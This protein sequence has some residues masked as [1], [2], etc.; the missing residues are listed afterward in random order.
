M[1]QRLLRTA[2]LQVQHRHGVVTQRIARVAL[3]HSRVRG[4]VF[5]ARL[6]ARCRRRAGR[7]QRC[8][9]DELH[10]E[11][12]HLVGR[13]LAPDD[14]VRRAERIARIA[15]RVVEG[16]THADRAALRQ[17]D[18]RGVPVDVLPPEVPVANGDQRTDGPVGQA[19]FGEH[20]ATE[21][22][23]MRL[24]G[25]HLR[26][27]RQHVTVADVVRRLS[28]GNVDRLAAQPQPD[29]HPHRRNVGEEETD[30]HLH[31][32]GLAGRLQMQLHH[33]VA[34]RLEAPRH[35]VGRRARLLTGRPPE[36]VPGRI[37]RVLHHPADVARLW[38]GGVE[39]AG[40]SRAVDA[41]VRV[42]HPAAVA[43]PEL[44]RAGRSERWWLESAA[45][46]CGRDRGRQASACTPRDIDT[47]RSGWPSCQ[48][49][50]YA[51]TGG[52]ARGS[53]SG[54]PCAAQS[55]MV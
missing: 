36:Q 11:V 34:P 55:W 7:G 16:E 49:S 37:G 17:L 42:M 39:A 30:A 28:R 48:P 3:Q 43:R 31:R 46:R 54:P 22:V 20:L 50:V 23:R 47:T 41:E 38:I 8:A 4:D 25:E 2:V 14:A 13:V 35:A 18:R 29:W 52:S 26:I 21:I 45:R 6:P 1:C 33:E 12:A 15:G 10:P 24:H 5:G 53:P 27:N 19:R 44:H 9:R 40:R 51:G 32:F